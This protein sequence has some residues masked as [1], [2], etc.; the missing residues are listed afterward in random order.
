MLNK[1]NIIDFLLKCYSVIAPI[2]I[3][4][5]VIYGNIALF[6]FYPE[7]VNP[8]FC[9]MSHY[10]CQLSFL[11]LAMFS[12]SVAIM[13]YICIV[14]YDKT[15]VFGMEKLKH[16]LL[17]LHILIPI[18]I[19]AVHVVSTGNVDPMMTINKCWKQETL[20][21]PDMLCGDRKYEVVQYLGEELGHYIEL[22]LRP[23]CAGVSGFYILTTCNMAEIVFYIAIAR[24]LKR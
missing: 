24:F 16:M 23:L 12:L 10:I 17:L 1:T 13:R 9:H 14:H 7:N 22:M 20:T 18:M 2:A 19:T 21:S 11:Y 3:S 4:C 5:G 8:W 6:D 15:I